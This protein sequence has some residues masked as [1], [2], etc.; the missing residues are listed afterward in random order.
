MQSLPAP[1]NIQNLTPIE[2]API[3][4]KLDRK[5][6]FEVRGVIVYLNDHENWTNQFIQTE[7]E[8]TPEPAPE[9]KLYLIEESEVIG[10]SFP[11]FLQTGSII[12]SG[13][14]K[15]KQIFSE[16]LTNL[17]EKLRQ[18]KREYETAKVLSEL[19]VPESPNQSGDESILSEEFPEI[20]TPQIPK[21][22]SPNLEP[23]VPK[24]RKQE[25]E[26]KPYT[27]VDLIDCKRPNGYCQCHV[28]EDSEPESPPQEYDD[29]FYGF[30]Y[31]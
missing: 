21:R 16:K 2:L 1:A 12:Q 10:T 18:K 23:E 24:K 5:N 13:I 4:I 9:P 3:K 20:P 22:E 29:D 19:K 26:P 17:M 30:D 6:C 8:S 7:E 27:T 14:K 15:V 31:N 28:T 25:I 11:S